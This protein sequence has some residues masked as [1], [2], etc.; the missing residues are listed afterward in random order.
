MASIHSLAQYI[1]GAVYFII[2]FCEERG[3]HLQWRHV[4]AS[5]KKNNFH[6][7]EKAFV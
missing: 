4:F 7:Y 5:T 2:M 1:V 6:K 3:L